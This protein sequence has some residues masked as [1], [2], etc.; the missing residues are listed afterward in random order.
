D[1]TEGWLSVRNKPHLGWQVKTRNERDVPLVPVLTDVLRIAAG[2]RTSGPVF[3]QRRCVAE[4]EPPLVGRDRRQ[5]EQEI[6]RRHRLEESTHGQQTRAQRA[7]A[8]AGLWRDLGALKEDWV[9]IEFMRLTHK[10]GMNEVT[11]PKTLR[12]TFATV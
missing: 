10:I 4:Y 3:R 8:A 9:R 11:A 5:L 6:A 1:L 7:V 12:H 2:D